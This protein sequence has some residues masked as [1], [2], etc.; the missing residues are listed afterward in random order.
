MKKL[1]AIIVTIVVITN[2]LLNM[3]DNAQAAVADAVDQRAA[4]IECVVNYNC[5]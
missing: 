4:T 2:A 5:K 3:T 1:L